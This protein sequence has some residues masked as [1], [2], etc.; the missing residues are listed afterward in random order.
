VSSEHRCGRGDLAE[1]TV[2]GSIGHSFESASVGATG[3]G[4]IEVTLSYST[5]TVY[6]ISR[7]FHGHKRRYPIFRREGACTQDLANV[8]CIPLYGIEEEPLTQLASLY[9]A[10]LDLLP[11]LKRE[12]FSLILRKLILL[13]LHGVACLSRQRHGGRHSIPLHARC[14]RSHSRLYASSVRSTGPSRRR[15]SPA[16]RAR[17]PARLRA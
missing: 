9:S 6:V 2:C 11:A 8:Y 7:Y 17:C 12:A 16:R 5:K 15:S 3:R 13:R 14:E 1:V 10:I 4:N